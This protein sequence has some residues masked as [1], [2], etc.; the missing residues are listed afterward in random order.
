MA[1]EVRVM[2]KEQTQTHRCA[3][4]LQTNIHWPGCAKSPC[5]FPVL[6]DSVNFTEGK[7]E[8]K[9]KPDSRRARVVE[10]YLPPKKYP[11][12]WLEVFEYLGLTLV[13]TGVIIGLI[14]LL[15][16]YTLWNS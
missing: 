5:P 11:G 13:C 4:C 6:E 7:P 3:V 15:S 12:F 2:S 10:V 1:N 9:T 14:F 8:V 16:Y